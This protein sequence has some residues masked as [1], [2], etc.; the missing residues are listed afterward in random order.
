M[1]KKDKPSDL[2][3]KISSF[4]TISSEDEFMAVVIG[5]SSIE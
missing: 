3:E 1:N 4:N 5:A 2:F